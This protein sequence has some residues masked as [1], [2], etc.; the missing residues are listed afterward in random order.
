[1]PIGKV[2]FFKEDRG[3]GFIMP[4]DGDSDIFFHVSS[5]KEGDEIAPGVAVKFD[6]GVD[7]KTGK[8][9][10]VCVDLV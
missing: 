7:K 2:K 4:D 9:R 10:A 1:M 3:F 8:T 5:L 6:L